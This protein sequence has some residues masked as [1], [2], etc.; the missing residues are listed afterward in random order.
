MKTTD[1]IRLDLEVVEELRQDLAARERKLAR[2]EAFLATQPG[3]RLLN[4]NEQNP[5]CTKNCREGLDG[6]E[7]F[8]PPSLCIANC[9]LFY[10]RLSDIYGYCGAPTCCK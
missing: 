3:G 10:R 1:E 7:A 2:V 8:G 4:I 9:C 5:P 6:A